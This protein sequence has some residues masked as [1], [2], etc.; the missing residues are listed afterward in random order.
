[1]NDSATPPG[2]SDA[3][4]PPGDQVPVGFT[5]DGARRIVEATRYV[6]RINRRPPASRPRGP[7]G[8][9]DPRYARAPSGGIPARVGDTVGKAMCTL[10]HLE[11][12]VLVDDGRA[13][14]VNQF[15]SIVGAGGKRLVVAVISGRLGVI[16]E[17]C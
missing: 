1:M 8:G 3:P 6:E 13:E 11:G 15:G 16:S 17:D 7:A 5:M 12:D 4:I 10:C 14:V 2:G 9:S